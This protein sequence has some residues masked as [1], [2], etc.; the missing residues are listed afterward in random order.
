MANGAPPYTFVIRKKRTGTELWYFRHPQLA[1]TP[2]LPGRPG[3]VAFHRRY[4]DLLEEAKE[5]RIADIQIADTRSM[6]WLVMNFKASAEWDELSDSTRRAYISNLDRLNAMAGDLPYSELTR[7]GVLAMRSTVKKEVEQSRKEAA[8]KRAE[9]DLEDAKAGRTP[10]RKPPKVTSGS[11]SADLFKSVV[12]ALLSWAVDHEYLEENPA[13]GSRK[14]QKRKNINSHKPWTEGQ[15]LEVLRKAPRHIRDGVVVGLY[16]GQRLGDSIGMGKKQCVLPIVRVR[17]QKTGNLVD[18]HAIG[19]M[20]ELVQ[21]RLAKKDEEDA[22]VLR[23]DGAPYN[24]RLF[25]EHLRAFLDG[26]G[27]E[28]I[29]FHGLRYAAAATLNEAGCNVATITAIIGHSTY[30]MALKYLS[31]RQNA[32]LAASMLEKVDA[33]RSAQLQTASQFTD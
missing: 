5:A 1:G 9:K 10:K 17:Q 30:Q 20:L 18:V 26:L 32:A 28:D 33:N 29:S 13:L 21:R 27:Y 15:I 14:L 2:R 19:P 7:S 22:L 16:T 6:R 24:E 31:S 12:S 25:S 11:R 8:Q 3:D 23:E 4:T